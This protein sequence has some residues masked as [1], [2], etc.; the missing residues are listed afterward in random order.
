MSEKSLSQKI[1]SGVKWKTAERISLQIMN[2]VTPIILARILSPDDFG[3]V[4]I[5]SVFISIANTFVN[6]GLCNAIVQKKDCDNVDCSTVFFTQFSIAVICYVVLFFAAP[7]IA[8][9]YANSMLAPM[10]HVMSLSL[11]IGAFSSMHVA[12]LK[13]NMMFNRSFI[14]N[15][16][17]VVSYGVVGIGC[18]MMGMGCWS[19][20]FA[21]VAQSLGL[22]LMR[23]LVIRWRPD[24]VFSF[25]RLARLFSYS[26]KL[27]V[28][29]FIGTLHQDIYTLVI[30][31]KFSSAVLGFYN[32]AVSI[33]T[34]FSKTITE[35]S[36]GVMFPAL[37][38]IQ[39]EKERFK[40]MSRRFLST[41]AFIIFPIFFGLSAI[42]KPLTLVLLTEKWLPSV[43]MMRIVCITFSLNALNN[44]NM[45]IFNSIGRSDIFMKFEL[46]KRTLSIVLL[47]V[48]SFVSI[49]AVICV[50]L[51]MAILSN[52]MNSWQNSR[53]IGYEYIQQVRD[54]APTVCSAAIMAICVYIVGVL[55]EGRGMANII[56]LAIQLVAGVL[57][58]G[59][60][61]FL[62]KIEAIKTILSRIRR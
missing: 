39:N 13:K 10:L 47:V 15:G 62:F 41:N 35:V 31:K 12:I 28:G 19:L 3:V 56:I 2:A 4:A 59:S 58:Y 1:V 25:S 9:Y 18:A 42:A 14:I 44:S 6:N 48:M 11:I 16:V 60:L 27:T 26:W 30:G 40:E 5:L 53:L 33:P 54:I 55:A 34:I 20:V 61:A 51:L 29:W 24:F 7:F 45:Q 37:A 32:R 38:S 23:V 46:V 52:A 49:Y 22:S 50:L 43:P 57:I 8:A 36:D 21:N 17:A